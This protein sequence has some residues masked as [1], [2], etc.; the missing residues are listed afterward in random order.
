MRLMAA[1]ALAAML[2][3]SSVNVQ[4]PPAPGGAAASDS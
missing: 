1:I 3:G 2:G 4:A